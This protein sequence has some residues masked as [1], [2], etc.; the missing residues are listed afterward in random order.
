MEKNI[1]AIAVGGCGNNIIQNL[2]NSHSTSGTDLFYIDADNFAVEKSSVHDKLAVSEQRNGCGGDQE[3]GRTI[4]LDSKAAIMNKFDGYSKIVFIAGLAGGMAGTVPLMAEWAGQE[5]I[6]VTGTA[7]MPFEFEG[8]QKRENAETTFEKWKNSLKMIF[9][10]END[11]LCKLAE[12]LKL[13]I[14]MDDL[15]AFFNIPEIIDGISRYTR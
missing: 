1:L 8:P 5:N 12:C 4:I 9:V 10:L 11:K 3:F 6:F 2:I 7:I 15:D 13:N 14:P